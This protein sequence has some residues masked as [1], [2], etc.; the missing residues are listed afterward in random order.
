MDKQ[1]LNNLKFLLETYSEGEEAVK[2]WM[3]SID[4]D[5]LEYALNLLLNYR[6]QKEH[7]DNIINSIFE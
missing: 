5:E 4:Q 1:D 3:E 2:T 7:F 6:E